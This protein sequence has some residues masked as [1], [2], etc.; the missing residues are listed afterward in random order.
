MSKA[1]SRKSRGHDYDMRESARSEARRSGKSLGDWLDDAIREDDDRVEEEFEHEDGDRLE[2][3]ARRLARPSGAGDERRRERE[4]Y[5]QPRRWRDDAADE[6]R[7]ARRRGGDD[8]IF[9]DDEDERGHAPREGRDWSH[10]RRRSREEPRLDAKAIVADAAAIVERRVAESE[11]HTARAFA[12]LADLIKRG[13]RRSDGDVVKRAV[14]AFAQRAQESERHTARAL[15]NLAGMLEDGRRNGETAEEGL[16]FLAE[17]LG[18]IESRLAEQPAAGASVRPIRSALARLESRL[19]RLS[20]GERAGEFEQALSSLDQRLADISRRLDEDARAP[21]SPP[22]ASQPGPAPEA[23]LAGASPAALDQAQR[24]AEPL[25][26]R[27]LV[28]AI[29]EITQRQRALDE[30]AP[31]AA[32]EPDIWEGEPPAK[33]FAQMHASLDSLSHQLETVRQ[34]AGERADQQMVVMRQIEG[35]RREVEDMSRAIGDLAPRASVAAIETALRD[36]AHRVDVQRHRGVADDLL[37][38]AERIAGELRAVIKELDPS[39]IVRNLHADVQT[40]GRRLDAMQ[41]PNAADVAA[42]RQLSAQTREI[43][44]QLSALAAR[45]LPIEKIETRLFDLTQRVDALAHAGAGAAKAAAALDMGELVRSIRSIVSAETT[46]GF[47]TFNRRLEQLATKL[48]E[49]VL[50]A[51]GKRFDELGERIDELGRTLSRRIDDSV[52][53]KPVD[54]ESLEAL[55]ANLAV[56]IDSALDGRP[57]APGFE[58]IGRKIERLETRIGD[59]VASDSIA[60]IEAMLQQPVADRQFAELAQRIDF[61]RETLAQRLDQG[62]AAA[63]AADVRYIEEIVRGLDHKIESAIAANARTPDLGAIQH[64]LEALF[65]KVDRLEDAS[66]N[67]RFGA[68]LAEPQSN[69]QLEEIATHLERMQSALSQRAEEGYRVEARQNDL[70][71]LVEQ[72]AGRLNQALDPRADSEALRALEAQIGAL[73]QRLDSNDHSGSALASVEARIGALVAQMEETKAATTLAA[74]EAVRRATQDLLR[75]A[76]PAPGALR[77]ALERELIDIRKIQDESGQRTHETLLA[78][79]ETLERVVDRLAI[80]EDE[81]SDI[82]NVPPAPGAALRL[83][84]VEPGAPARRREEAPSPQAG[85]APEPTVEPRR[86]PRV[87]S[88]EDDLV[89]FL[90]PPGAPRPPRRE[91]DF[92]PIAEDRAARPEAGQTDFI[93]AARRA[94]QQA[95]V[96]ADAAEKAQQARRAAGRPASSAPAGKAAGLAATLEDRKRPLL[97]GLAGVVLLAGAFGMT[98]M[99]LQGRGDADHQDHQ[100]TEAAPAETDSAPAASSA[101]ESPEAAPKESPA[102]AAAPAATPAPAPAASASGRSVPPVTS[103]PAEAVRVVRPP[104]LSPETPRNMPTMGP[105]GTVPPRMIAPHTENTPVDSTPVGSIGGL[106]PLTAPDATNVIKSLAQQGDASAQYELAVRYADGRGVSRDAKTAAQW[107]EKAAEQGL[108]PAQYRLGSLYEKGI[109]VERDYGRA[110]KYYQSAAEAGNARAMH[111]LAVLLAEGGAGGKP[112]YAAA[113]QWFVRA[114]DLG[115]RDSQFNLAILYARGLGVSQSLTQ[116]YLWFAAAADQGDADAAKK[117][118]EVAARLDSKDLSTAKSLAAG[119]KAKEPR[120]EANDVLPPKGGWENVKDPP[121]SAAKPAATPSAK[122]LQRPKISA[123]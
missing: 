82:R 69:A 39:P 108:A 75:Q 79:H 121:A 71:A 72:L 47:D 33:R 109:G 63:P 21:Q 26:R 74:E 44:D 51:G 8:D 55:I 17:R 85:R 20:S 30:A 110:R 4:D 19:D 48:D 100:V 106:N 92:S 98:R 116:S 76:N 54:T 89:D 18:R 118:D 103:A 53:Q 29:A 67:N 101:A 115:V 59:P 94:A 113:A 65:H 123:I 62:A 50:N 104:A 119:F 43:R 112:D 84:A 5:R 7:A 56:K 68:M 49:A 6:M 10:S 99:A 86:A 70:A 61:V 96:D 12:N 111:N 97:L 14:A 15:D 87:G 64:Q 78:V 57:H 32:P 22:A 90:V 58:E 66:A 31:P 46:A 38:P 24:R 9:S 28:D 81:L 120:R 107:F 27:P 41:Q 37:A 45:P 16:A 13:Q 105:G 42:I 91:P 77:E 93:A 80:F 88:D 95:A 73:S 25:T 40:I 122:S 102:R 83:D 60:R 114:A 3:V 2:A 23:K 117:R 34:D 52:A 11:R 35:L 36:L 1:L